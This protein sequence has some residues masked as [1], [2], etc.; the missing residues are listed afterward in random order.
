MR[1]RAR[2]ASASDCSARWTMRAFRRPLAVWRPG[3]SSS[4]TWASGR[5]MIPRIRA[6]VV[7]GLGLMM[8][9]FWPISRLRSVLLPTLGRPTMATKPA[10]IYSPQRRR[11][12][13]LGHL[14][15]ADD[16][17]VFEL[18]L[19][20]S[21]P[22]DLRHQILPL[23]HL[24]ED[25]VAAVQVRD[26]HFGDEE[27]RSVGVRPRIGHRQQSRPIELL[28][29]LELVLEAVPRAARPGPRRITALDHELRD[30]PVEDGA[31]VELRLAFLLCAWI[32]RF[33]LAGCQ[34]DE[35]RDRLGRLLLEQ[36][37]DDVAAAGLEH[38]VE[39]AGTLGDVGH[40]DH[41]LCFEPTRSRL[42]LQ[43]NGCGCRR[44]VVLA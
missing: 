18:R 28:P 36:L 12:P 24:A 8:A 4:A 25:G 31:V 22:C 42:G 19:R 33:L 44:G 13:R 40:R 7:C 39:I 29:A 23:D 41:V 32:D 20:V 21:A 34:T 2:S 10:R 5:V 3:V 37:D 35:V 15:A 9:S 14:L 30:H 16:L 26:R 11:I 1:K 38:G 17:D 43:G 27:L 6:R